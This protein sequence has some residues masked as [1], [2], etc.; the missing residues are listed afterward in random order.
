MDH[1]VFVVRLVPSVYR[2]PGNIY[3]V[4]G[5]I[6]LSTKHLHQQYHRFTC[7]A[8]SLNFV[9]IA[10]ESDERAAVVLAVSPMKSRRILCPYRLRTLRLNPSGFRALQHPK[11]RTCLVPM[12]AELTV[13]PNHA[14]IWIAYY[15][16]VHMFERTAVVPTCCI[17]AAAGVGRFAWHM[18]RLFLPVYEKRFFVCFDL[19]YL[20]V[21]NVFHVFLNL[22]IVCIRNIPFRPLDSNDGSCCTSTRVSVLLRTK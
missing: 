13:T 5:I 4:P 15:S 22:E 20:V 3:K 10:A 11:T 9:K 12:R 2:G 14:K 8:A 18:V 16:S 21:L 6:R 1:P 17:I 19:L 7:P